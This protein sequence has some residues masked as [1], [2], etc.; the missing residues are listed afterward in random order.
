MTVGV[1]NDP[2]PVVALGDAASAIA[3]ARRAALADR[4]AANSFTVEWRPL[5]RLEP[6]SAQWRELAARALEP[7][8]FYEPAFALAAAP[9]FGAEAGAVLVW[10]SGG[11]SR[12]LL[13][14]FPARIERRR[15][16]FYLPVLVGW[17]HPYAPLGLP[18]VE[19]E[20]AEPIIGAFLSHLA[21]DSTLPNL[22][23]LP[24]LPE[25][26][27]FAATLDGILRR[28][29][30]PSAAFGRHRRALLAPVSERA[31]YLDGAMSARQRKELRRQWRR[32]ADTGAIAITIAT[33]PAAVDRALE[34]FFSLEALGWKG[35]AGTA[36]ADDE[37]VQGFVRTALF[38]LAADR[39]ASINRLLVDGRAVAATV[40]LRSGHSAW[41]W[42][43]AYN[44]DFARFSP[45]VM[46]SVELTG[47]LLDD[48]TMLCADSCATA[49]HPMIDHLWRE[50]L[51]LADR[52]I[53]VGGH[54]AFAAAYRLEGLRT[55]AITGAKRLRGLLRG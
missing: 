13:G 45:G 11:K 55:A 49:N 48:T 34:D 12:R 38:K 37:K 7:N 43:I 16:G 23:L 40:A 41:F 20:A 35:R 26:G 18:L 31:H 44:E 33:E 25:D 21:E 15:Y 2:A 4:Y 5:S 46:L 51:S 50:R 27:P 32:L 42:K 10:S 3:T 52:L 24:F 1:S 54:T 36:A 39:K 28:A 47:E 17:T 22:V 14:F 19:R 9:V 53:G 8:V 6:I 30:M 29:D